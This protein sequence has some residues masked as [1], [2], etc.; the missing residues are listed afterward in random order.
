MLFFSVCKELDAFKTSVQILGS[1]SD[2]PVGLTEISLLIPQLF[3]LDTVLMT[4]AGKKL[5]VVD[6][7]AERTHHFIL[8]SLIYLCLSTPMVLK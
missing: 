5:I 6:A 1:I 2:I 8:Q 4:Y 3:F 7:H